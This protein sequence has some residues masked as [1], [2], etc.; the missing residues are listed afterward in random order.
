MDQAE[1]DAEESEEQ[2][3]RCQR[4]GCRIANQHEQHHAAE[5]Q[6]RKV[7]A[8]PAHC[9]G[10]SYLKSMSMTCSSAATRLMI[11][12]MPCNAIRKNPTGSSSFTGQR[13]SPPAFDDSSWSLQDS[14]N[15]GHVK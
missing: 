7:R 15:H 4:E 6:G 11:S 12:E 14:T 9:S 8:D 5:H 10:F 1:L 13:S 2:P 3:C